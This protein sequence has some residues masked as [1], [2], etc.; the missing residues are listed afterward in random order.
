MNSDISGCFDREN[1][2][3]FFGLKVE[4]IKFK[5]ENDKFFFEK[6]LSEFE[7]KKN[8]LFSLLKDI[9]GL[10]RKEQASIIKKRYGT[11]NIMAKISFYL[12]DSLDG[13][14]PPETEIELFIF[15]SKFIDA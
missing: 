12:L 15:C 8:N 11:K 4:Q 3:Q 14:I 7:N 9:R 5:Q 6:L 10:S 1:L 13:N 2:S